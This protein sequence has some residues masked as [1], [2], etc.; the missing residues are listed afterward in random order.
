MNMSLKQNVLS[1][2]FY[3]SL[4][5]LCTHEIDAVAH[6]E[7]QL[8]PILSQMPDE[9]GFFWF[10]VLHIPL[11]TLIFWLT[12]HTSPI[13]ARRSRFYLSALLLVHGVIH[14]LLS[15]HADYTFAPP[16]ETITVY[17]AAVA[18]LAYMVIA[19]FWKIGTKDT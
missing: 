6:S 9:V 1:L 13:V 19:S 10:V 3:F 18:G 16:I 2:L 17:G 11:F 8:L 5:L 14:F 12:T 4:A 15:G 7:W